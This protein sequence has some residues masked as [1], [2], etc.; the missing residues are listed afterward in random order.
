MRM[1]Q[2]Y[3]NVS[4]TIAITTLAGTVLCYIFDYKN[5]R[6]DVNELVSGLRR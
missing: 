3:I 6:H 1:P 2:L 4:Q 5:F